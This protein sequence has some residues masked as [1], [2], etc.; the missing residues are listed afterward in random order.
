MPGRIDMSTLFERTCRT[1]LTAGVLLATT[2][3]TVAAQEGVGSGICGTPLAETVNQAAP[4]IVGTLMIGASILAYILHTAAA[5]PRD[6]QSVQTIKNWR[7]RAAI[8]AITTPLFAF[9]IE[10]F[11]GFTGTSISNCVS[12]VPFF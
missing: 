2:S 5:F 7:N 6:P 3:T 12:L 8:S 1:V 9:V 4:L 11:I 10:M